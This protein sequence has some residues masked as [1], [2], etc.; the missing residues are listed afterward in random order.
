[1]SDNLIK[2]LSDAEKT[3]ISQEIE[4]KELTKE[5]DKFRDD[6]T[7]HLLNGTNNF[8]L[9]IDHYEK[10]DKEELIEKLTI[11]NGQLLKTEKEIDRLNEEIQIMEIQSKNT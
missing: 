5:N 2:Q 10:C 4:I 11:K 7:V 1:M 3:I 9:L 6:L 8:K